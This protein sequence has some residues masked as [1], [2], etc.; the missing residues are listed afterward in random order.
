MISP[1]LEGD[2]DSAASLMLRIE[3]AVNQLNTNKISGI[4]K[5]NRYISSLEVIMDH[6]CSIQ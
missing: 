4:V 3:F 6:N 2:F 1:Y 5:T